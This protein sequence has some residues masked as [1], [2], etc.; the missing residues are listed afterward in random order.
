MANEQFLY[1]LSARI[2]ANVGAAFQQFENKAQ[3][4][5]GKAAESFKRAER[6]V[7]GVDRKLRAAAAGL[8]V[9][10]GPLG[11]LASRVNA[12]AQVF[13]FMGRSTAVAI[14][15]IGAFGAAIGAA[16]GVQQYQAKLVAATKSQAEFIKAQELATLTARA[17]RSELGETIQF[18]VRL[19]SATNGLGVSQKEL[20]NVIGTVQKSIQLSGVGA[21]EATA[22]MQQFSQ[23]IGSAS[24][25]SGDEFKSLGENANKVLQVIAE[26][27]V[28][29][30]AIP[31][32]D[33][34]IG[35]LKK[36][37]AEGQLTRDKLLPALAA[38]QGSVDDL[39]SRMPLTISQATNQLKTSL[40]ELVV[41]T[42]NTFG[43]L[44]ATAGAISFV[45]ENLTLLGGVATVVGAAVAARFI[46]PLASAGVAAG[47]AAIRFVGL[48][49]GIN[50]MVPAMVAQGV[51]ASRLSIALAALATPANIASL[52][53]VAAAGA[54]YFLATRQTEAQQAAKRMGVTESEL[55][56]EVRKLTGYVLGQNDA[57]AK[58]IE[59]KTRRG[60]IA[61]QETLQESASSDVSNRSVLAGRLTE[62]GFSRGGSQSA[63]GKAFAALA[64]E[65]NSNLDAASLQAKLDVLARRFPETFSS[66][67]GRIYAAADDV[68][69]S[70]AALIKTRQNLIDGI[71][72]QDGLVALQDQQSAKKALFKSV[73][74]L[75]IDGKPFSSG[76]TKTKKQIDAAAAASA[77]DAGTQTIAAASTR[78]RQAIADLE[79]SFGNIGKATSEQQ[80]EYTKQRTAIEE[81][82]RS[83]VDAVQAAAAAKK[84]A[85]AADRTADALE[86]A[87]RRA[88][89]ADETSYLQI[90]NRLNPNTSR[91]RQ[92]GSIR[93]EVDALNKKRAD[94]GLPGYTDAELAKIDAGIRQ[95]LV[96]PLIDANIVSSEQATIQGL[97]LAGRE[98][99]AEVLQRAN[100][101]IRAGVDASQIDLSLIGQ[102]VEGERR[103]NREIE[104]RN[105]LVENFARTAGEVKGA[106]TDFLSGGSIKN[107][108]PSL[109]ST[110][111]KSLGNFL[112]DSIFG[113]P[114]ADARAAMT[115][116][117]DVNTGAL[118]ELKIAVKKLEEEIGGRGPT[119]SGG[120]PQ[121]PIP[122]NDNTPVVQN[123]DVA[124]SQVGGATGR[125]FQG[126]FSIFTDVARVF[127]GSTRTFKSSVDTLVGGGG[128]SDNPL[129]N[130]IGA[131][132]RAGKAIGNQ[133]D[134]LFGG[135]GDGG[136]ALAKF[137][138]K[139][140]GA[141]AGAL[142]GFS[143]GKQVLGIVEDLGIQLGSN[144][145]RS[146]KSKQFAAGGAVAGATVGFF[147][148]GPVGAALGAAIGTVVGGIIGSI[149]KTTNLAFKGV[150]VDKF[151]NVDKSG[152]RAAGDKKDEQITG[153]N[154]LA[155]ALLKT[156]GSLKDALGA[157]ISPGASLG[158]IGSYKGKFAFNS[159]FGK[160]GG[161]PQTFETAS[162]AVAAAIKS[163]IDN[164]IITGM[165]QGVKNLLSAGKDLEQQ[166][167]KAGK[168]NDVFRELQRAT[169][170]VGFAVD[171]LN[172][173]FLDLANVFAEASA[174][175]DDYAKLQQLY[176]LQRADALKTAGNATLAS[177]NAYLTELTTSSS[178]G[179][180]AR[181]RRDAAL[182]AFNPLAADISAGKKV[183]VDAYRTAA[184]NLREVERELFGSTQ[185]Y[186]DRLGQITDLTRQAIAGQSNVTSIADALNFN[187]PAQ[188]TPIT[189]GLL[190]LENTL[191]IG[192]DRTNALLEQML[193]GMGGGQANFF[194]NYAVRNF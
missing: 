72:K 190:S 94:A 68:A 40:T 43:P 5:G 98:A 4:A 35:A 95:F 11:G 45:A 157:N 33:G 129:S 105:R 125:A 30:N 137:G 14:T 44:K 51:A 128:S 111:Q 23:A 172:R 22:A 159:I 126:F 187:A 144:K 63:Q 47:L 112:S 13:Q 9:F 107:I 156:V 15:A 174:S 103:R 186:F 89:I 171:E 163:G 28:K 118:D 67:G 91:G 120:G 147:L 52:A 148:G 85:R 158:E 84:A 57:L 178:S 58:N 168:F 93:I 127:R 119:P 101:L 109:F 102:Q 83:E 71:N 141:I 74:S 123:P 108:I 88:A 16:S 110:F 176:D 78:R 124:A 17:S 192:Q 21:Q 38:M 32:F 65:V 60:Q 75:G 114:E 76:T 193:S 34:S 138:G 80:A 136:G 90:L 151:G 87:Q 160:D 56:D 132:D 131:G 36:L 27:L 46:A 145:E 169:D 50:G 191:A 77:I 122:S 155:D 140:G 26:G 39:F 170:P 121:S 69:A 175:A 189:N 133:F 79:A 149:F 162:E 7:D 42:E 49:A 54:A 48:L 164:N 143:V 59:L 96:Q 64:R 134:K 104:L 29:T 70:S 117:L 180:S 184:E 82:Y 142:A 173:K 139:A 31:G 12:T 179:L 146:T 18:Y 24:G 97:I 1:N 130:F 10:Q 177:L 86:R 185:G 116:A 194:D 66:F 165:R 154:E 41:K 183:D 2:D 106:F 182:A 6:S 167:N 100:A 25:L 37:G 62:A 150:S 188:I 153:A 8:A 166:L 181:D 161:V 135:S 61:A 115:G 99:D 20:F 53:F 152:T 55:A 19:A 73:A 81:R 113:D 3:Q 92:A